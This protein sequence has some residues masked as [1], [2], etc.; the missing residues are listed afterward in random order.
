MAKDYYQV[1]GVKR[2]ASSDEIQK[3]FHRLA[4]QHHP[5][6]GGNEQKFKEV[7]EA[8]QVLSDKEKRAQYDQFGRV[9]SGSSG[10]PDGFNAGNWS[11]GTPGNGE[12]TNFDF[13]DLGDVFE[14]FFGF[15]QSRQ[16]K[17]NRRGQDIEVA[18]EVGLAETLTGHEKEISLRKLIHCDRCQG[19]G[20]EPGSR[21]RECFSCRGQ[22]QV[23]QVKRTFLGSFTTVV[24][25]PECK[26]E[27]TKPEK[28]CQVCSGEGRLKGLEKIR[29]FVPAGIDNNQVV[30][31]ESKGEAG[32]KNARPGDLYVR[33]LIK[34][35]PG[36]DRKGDDLFTVLPIPFAKMVLGG[37]VELMDLAG[38]KIVLAIPA[39]AEP[40]KLLRLSG[41]GIPHFQG[42]GWGDLYVKLNV[43]IPKKVTPSQ[44]EL[45]EKLEN[46][47]L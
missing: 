16:S 20:A 25:C 12:E 3:A 15:G 44:K 35:H 40:N 9:F 19:S 43:R 11:W 38:R 45:L 22:G 7:N 47:D 29:V 28:P 4:H 39:G 23:Q 41:K 24:T 30:R 2:T 37:K 6:K 8:Y 42:R 31:V 5:D 46:E 18:L 34:K 14:D 36:F 13:G 1:L 17:D 26:G 21:A 10:Q 32:K 33:F 27:G